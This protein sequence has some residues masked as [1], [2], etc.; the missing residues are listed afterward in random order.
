MYKC[1]NLYTLGWGPHVS[2]KASNNKRCRHQPR[3]PRV[4]PREGKRERSLS[5]GAV[6]RSPRRRRAPCL[7]RPI[8]AARAAAAAA[9]TR[10]RSSRRRWCCGRCRWGSRSARAGGGSWRPWP[11][12]LPSSRPPAPP[13]APPS[14]ATRSSSTP[15]FRSCTPRSRRPPVWPLPPPPNPPRLVPWLSR[16]PCV[17]SIGYTKSYA[18]FQHYASLRT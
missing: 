2:D 1:L 14:P 10:A 8:A 7:L 9:A 11:Q 13:C 6:L 18:L 15:P 12:G 4:S 16:F 5:C 3:G 17:G